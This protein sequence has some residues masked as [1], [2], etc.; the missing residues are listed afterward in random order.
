MCSVGIV[1]PN[2]W[3]GI[4]T[5]AASF[6]LLLLSQRAQ[7]IA[8]SAITPNGTPTPAPTA[9]ADVPLL[10]SQ[11][12]VDVAALED[13]VA[14][15]V[16]DEDAAVAVADADTV[17]ESSSVLVRLANAPRPMIILPVSIVND[18]SPFGHTTLSPSTT[19]VP[20]Q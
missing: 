4:G 8:D 11:V 18:S 17:L 15:S 1:V 7:A 20:Q 19:G 13:C 2:S 14:A 5:A 16:A 12:A 3:G 6:L 9:V 10:L